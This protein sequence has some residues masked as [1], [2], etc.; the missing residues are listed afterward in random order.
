MTVIVGVIVAGGQASRM[1]N[2]DKPLLQLAGL[3]IIRHVIDLALPQLDALVISVNRNLSRYQQFDLPLVT[4]LAAN[5]GGPLVGIYSAMQWFHD[6]GINADYLACFPADVPV[7]PADIVDQLQS[8]LEGVTEQQS[9]SM[10]VS[11]PASHPA[12]NK[13]AWCQTGDQVQPLFSLWPFSVLPDLKRAVAQGIHG[14]RLFFQDHPHQLLKL[15]LPRPPQFFNINTPEQLTQAEQL[16]GP[17]HQ[18]R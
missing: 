3:P 2:A 8:A 6:Q 18:P 14:P 5:R 11:N 15:P 12:S 16:I 1:G 10:P 4:D 13:V 17:G 7:F 9:I